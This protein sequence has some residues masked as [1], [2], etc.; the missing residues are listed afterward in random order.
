VSCVFGGN[1]LSYRNSG[2]GSRLAYLMAA[3]AV[4][5]S[6]ATGRMLAAPA[7]SAAKDGGRAALE[8]MVAEAQEEAEDGVFLKKEETS[9][10]TD[11]I[12]EEMR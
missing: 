11:T 3:D 7:R 1:V 12:E 10:E 5:P 8:R 6:E 9:E 4:A 2:V